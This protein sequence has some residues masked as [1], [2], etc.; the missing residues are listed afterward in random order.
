MPTVEGVLHRDLKPGNV[1]LGPFG[2]TLVVDW[3]LA[4]PLDRIPEGHESTL[5][6]VKSTKADSA[7]LPRE[8]GQVIGTPPTC[9]PN[10]PKGPSTSSAPGA[11]STAWARSSTTCS[12]AIIPSR[13]RA[14]R[15]SST[16]VNSGKIKPPRQVR[17][18]IPAALEAV[19][20]KALALKPE[21]RYATPRALAADIKAW[22][23]DE[24]VSARPEPL[25]ERARRWAKRN[26]TAVTAAAAALL[27]GLVGLGA[28]AAVQTKARN[29]LAAKNV[30]LEKQRK[31]AEENEAQAIA[32][33][34]KF[35]DVIAN[36]PELKKTPALENLRKR[37]LNEPLAFFRA[38]RERLQADHDT[39]PESL[40]RL[41][42]AS[43]GLGYMTSEIGDKQ[44]ALVAYRES[45]AIQQK[46]A[47]A[48]PALTAFQSDLADIHH[49]IGL[50]L[51]R[52]RQVGRGAS[53]LRGGAGDPAEAGRVQPRRHRIS[54]PPGGQP[55][56]R[57]RL[58]ER[59]R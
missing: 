25:A 35:G 54:K 16:H 41:A 56:Q 18:E 50:N 27:V 37:L 49:N 3:G 29:D 52:D 55:H 48:N 57:R 51:K 53:G 44:D 19:C 43:Y 40:E 15:R 31:R 39:R 17:P 8:H 28:V 20:L 59:Q 14:L 7:S 46:L 30:D 45:L 34:K 42:K 5:G 26:R 23:A 36:E 22:L 13:V 58:A 2:E 24:P 9:R 4:L 47:E 10:R 33:V 21:D 11:T 12:R 6:P 1:M 38:L 32:A